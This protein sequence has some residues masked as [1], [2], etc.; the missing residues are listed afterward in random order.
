MRI[1]CLPICLS[2]LDVQKVIQIQA[3]TGRPQSSEPCFAMHAHAE[4]PALRAA[5]ATEFRG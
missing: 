4:K 1:Y 3:G 2:M 5:A